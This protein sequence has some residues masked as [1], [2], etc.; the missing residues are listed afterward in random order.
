MTPEDSVTVEGITED[1]VWY[2][3]KLLTQ[4][5]R[6]WNTDFEKLVGVMESRH[7]EHLRMLDTAMHENRIL[8]LRLKEKENGKTE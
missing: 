6:Q 8:K 1:Y 3:A 4:K 7:K 5:M 2:Q